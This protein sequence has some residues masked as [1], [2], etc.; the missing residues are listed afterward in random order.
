MGS[1]HDFG[2]TSAPGSAKPP[3][4]SVTTKWRLTHVGLLAASGV[5]ELHARHNSM[6]TMSAKPSAPPSP[7]H[8]RSGYS[9]SSRPADEQQDQH[10]D[11]ED[12]ALH[13][14]WIVMVDD[15]ATVD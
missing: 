9:H 13:R 12:R 8:P 15:Q 1:S 6:R 3:V 11:E 14:R 7:D 10:D 2:S 4:D 5:V